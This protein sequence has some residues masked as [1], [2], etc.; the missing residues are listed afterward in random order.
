MQS[1]ETRMLEQF[2]DDR[3]KGAEREPARRRSTLARVGF[4]SVFNS[5]RSNRRGRKFFHQLVDSASPASSL[6]QGTKGASK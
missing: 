5:L 4:I 6:W 2:A 1:K 3:C